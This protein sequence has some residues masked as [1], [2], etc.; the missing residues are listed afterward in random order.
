[1][2][3]VLGR[4]ALTAGGTAL[5]AVAA[6]GAPRRRDRSGAH[7]PG[8]VVLPRVHG[9]SVFRQL[10]TVARRTGPRGPCL[11]ARTALRCHDGSH[12]TGAGDAPS[13]RRGSRRTRRRA[14]GS[15]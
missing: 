13:Y 14:R 10:A 1:T 2:A 7:R 9:G 15:R 12:R 11:P 8:V 4:P 5:S 3:V 6:A